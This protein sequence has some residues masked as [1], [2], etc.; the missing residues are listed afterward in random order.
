MKTMIKNI[1]KNISPIN[2]Y[3]DIKQKIAKQKGNINK[4]KENNRI[5]KSK[6]KQSISK[7]YLKK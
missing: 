2:I 1:S 3:D 7:K 4:R 6:I 5:Y